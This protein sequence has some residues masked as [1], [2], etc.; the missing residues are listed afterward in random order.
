MTQT[1]LAVLERVFGY[2]SFRGQ[3]EAIIQTLVSGQDALVLMPTGGGKSLCYQL[4]ALVRDG[5]AVVISPLIALMQDQV[6]A[7]Q[8]LG[9]KAGY[10]NSAQDRAAQQATEDALLDGS[11]KLLYVA[12]ER[13]NQPRMMQLLTRVKLA[14][15]AI[16]EAHCVSQWG[17]DFRADYLQLGVLAEVFPQ[18]PR[19][20]LTATADLR[21]REEIAERLQL[22]HAA[23][24][25]S[26]FDRPNIQYRIGLKQQAR[27]QMLRFL[28]Q[29]HPGD[30]GVIYCLSRA[31][32]D[33]TAAWLQQ[34]GIKALPYHAG[35]PQ[36]MRRDHQQRFLREDGIV[37]VAT[38][39]FGM[40]IDKPDVRF[41]MHLDLPK[42][43]EGYYQETGRA[44]RDGEPATA[45]MLYGVEDIVKLRQMLE[46]SPADDTH[47]RRE[48][49]RLDAMLGLC[50]ITSC[51]RHALLRYFGEDSPEQCGA[52]DTCLTPPTTWDATESVRKA[53][54][55]VYRTGQRFG[56][57]HLVDVLR[58]GNTE[59]IRQFG[60]QNLSTYG[61]GSDLTANTWRSVF[62]QLVARGLL[63]VDVDG[64][65]A[66]H[67]TE[68]CRPL[69]R[70]ETTIALREDA[71]EPAP[72]RR[73]TPVAAE[74]DPADRPLWEALRRLRR[75]L[76]D[77]LGVPPYVV[78]NDRTLQDMVA[79]RPGTPQQMLQV[80]GVGE[81]KLERFGDDFLEVIRDHE[82]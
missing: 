35:L 76:A 42:S 25:I 57:N 1:P 7:L 34:Q 61:I 29:E 9:V 31:K 17:H 78:F 64:F 77:D 81:T 28:Q 20:A 21:T 70:G 14:L 56:V 82:Y 26:S 52:C 55:C 73:A 13:L 37:M 50:E 36:D 38:I 10:L 63:S 33:D 66:L 41:V 62:R 19:I 47:K 2:H 39:A 72:R 54:S 5:T 8:A 6:D 60:H 16:D 69:L 3:Q 32:V 71:S 45:L 75:R 53:L 58:G 80:T 22:T 46:Q 51:R 44:G 24:F 65:G 74:L 12:P 15:F 48:R 40:G 4:P 68:D 79:L 30:A 18:V 59:K 67:L 23:R 11:L 49:H 43:I 27:Q